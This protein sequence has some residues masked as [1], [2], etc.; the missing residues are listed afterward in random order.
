M[1]VIHEVPHPRLKIQIFNYNAKYIVKVELGQFE[2]SFKIGELDVMGLD[3]VIN[4]VN[5]EFLAGC[6]KR[7][8]S[9]REDWEHSFKK[10]N[11]SQ[12]N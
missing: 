5:E 9:M 10:K 7:F 3:N 11:I 2:Q 6:V 12:N 8:V 1:R 4:M